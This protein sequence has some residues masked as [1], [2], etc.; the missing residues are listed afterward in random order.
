MITLHTASESNNFKD[1]VGVFSQNF[2]DVID[3]LTTDVDEA[4]FG[5]PRISEK[6]ITQSEKNADEVDLNSNEL[7]LANYISDKYKFFKKFF[8]NNFFKISFYSSFLLFL[9]EISKKQR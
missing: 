6:S 5:A 4:K 1:K 9:R 8:R 2:K 3:H 7:G